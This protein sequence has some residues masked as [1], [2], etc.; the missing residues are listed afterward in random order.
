MRTRVDIPESQIR[1]L[2][3]KINRSGAA[4]IR[5]AIADYLARR[6]RHAEQNAFGLWGAAAPDSMEYQEKARAEW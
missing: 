4:V 6:R 2:S 3:E 1:E 5:D